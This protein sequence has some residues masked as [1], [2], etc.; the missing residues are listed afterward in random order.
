VSTVVDLV[1]GKPIV[2]NAFMEDFVIARGEGSLVFLAGQMVDDIAMG[3]AHVVR[4]E[5]HLPNTPKQAVV[6]GRSARSAPHLGAHP[7]PASAKSCPSRRDRGGIGRLPC[8]GAS[9]R[10]DA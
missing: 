8:R 3:I 1:R 10:G 5:D 2:D 7:D 4:A 6:V 9:A